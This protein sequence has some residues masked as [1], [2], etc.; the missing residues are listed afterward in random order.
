MTTNKDFKFVELQRDDVCK[1]IL[2]PVC[3][4][5]EHIKNVGCNPDGVS[6]NEAYNCN[7]CD[8]HWEGY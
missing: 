8:A 7:N 3:L 6:C 1:G 2:C 4:T 5:S